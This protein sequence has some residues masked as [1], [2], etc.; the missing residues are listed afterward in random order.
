MKCKSCDKPMSPIQYHSKSGK[1]I[2]LL[3]QDISAYRCSWC[4]SIFLETGVD[5]QQIYDQAKTISSLKKQI[6]TKNKQI[7]DLE[8]KSYLLRQYKIDIANLIEGVYLYDEIR[9]LYKEVTK[10]N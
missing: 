2:P 4:G 3:Q 8:N 9:D 1:K 10:D 5:M 6:K 7:C